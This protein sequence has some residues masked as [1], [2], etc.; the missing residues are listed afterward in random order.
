M[1]LPGA[2]RDTQSRRDSQIHLTRHQAAIS[3]RHRALVSAPH[4]KKDEHESPLLPDSPNLPE[5]PVI[6]GAASPRTQTF[7]EDAPASQLSSLPA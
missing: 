6:P 2:W 3:A 4:N 7:L 1:L 5:F